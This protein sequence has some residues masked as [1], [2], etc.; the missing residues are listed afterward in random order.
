MIA[1]TAR[2]VVSTYSSTN[3]P[4][5]Q[6]AALTDA[7]VSAMR[8]DV[9]VAHNDRAAVDP[10]ELG[11]DRAVELLVEDL[12]HPQRAERVVAA[13]RDHLLDGGVGIE[14]VDPALALETLVQRLV[15]VEEEPHTLVPCLEAS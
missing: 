6:T 4:R 13:R 8:R 1:S 7:G 5:D 11:L 2:S 12:L 14:A 10:R 3:S 15:A 9:R